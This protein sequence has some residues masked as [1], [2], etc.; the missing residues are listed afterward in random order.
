MDSLKT[1]VELYSGLLKVVPPYR[2][3]GRSC[4]FFFVAM[5]RSFNS[6]VNGAGVDMIADIIFLEAC[7][8]I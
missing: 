8:A 2:R 7:C 3:Y 6:C 4:E 1:C 5:F